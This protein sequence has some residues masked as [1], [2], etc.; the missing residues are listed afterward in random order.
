MLVSWIMKIVRVKLNLKFLNETKHSNILL[1]CCKILLF[2]PFP[3]SSVEI[4]LGLMH[5]YSSQSQRREPI[6]VSVRSCRSSW[7][8]IQFA[9]TLMLQCW[10][11]FQFFFLSFVL[12]NPFGKPS[13]YQLESI[14]CYPHWN[15]KCFALNRITWR[16]QFGEIR[17]CLH[18]IDMFRG[19]EFIRKL[20]S[21]ATTLP[22][23]IP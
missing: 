1:L 17:N 12:T 15:A 10:Y 18:A 11:L 13:Q 22:N 8:Q 14:I 20:I 9:L 3:D 4:W 2:T 5:V 7:Q 23:N 21:R 6:K 19:N 16:N